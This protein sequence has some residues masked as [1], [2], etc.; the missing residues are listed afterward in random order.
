MFQ[1]ARDNTRCSSTPDVVGDLTSKLWM[2]DVVAVGKNSSR[3][4]QGAGW[5]S[6]VE[7]KANASDFIYRFL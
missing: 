3:D 2:S 4:T 6:V 5:W 7:A 1:A